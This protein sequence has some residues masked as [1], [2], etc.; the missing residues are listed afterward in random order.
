[1]NNIAHKAIVLK[2]N[3]QWIPVG[4][5]LV[6]KI[7]CDMMTGVV[8]GMDIV[9]ATNPDGTPNFEVQ[10]YVNPVRD[11]E[12]WAKLS[13]RPWD[14]CIHSTKMTFRVPTV[15]ITAKYA[16]VHEKKFKGKPTKE[17]LAIR[18]NLRDAY[19]GEELELQH[20]SVDHV[21]P[22]SRGGTDTYDNT[23]LTTKEINNRKGNKLNSE[24]GLTLLINPHNPKPILVSH[25][26]RK[27][28]H[29]DWR[30]FLVKNG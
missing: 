29:N 15:V 3:K 26:I 1:M 12:E 17:G 28:R 22:R 5:G 2:L 19:T 4:V 24:A 27:A 18:D 20:C 9:Y 6:S 21:I 30:S 7:I 10:E 11:W 13:V 25:T 16:K 23:V 14:L 8:L